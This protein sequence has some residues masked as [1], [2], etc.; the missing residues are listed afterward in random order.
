MLKEVYQKMAKIYKYKCIILMNL[1][2]FRDNISMMFN[3]FKHLTSLEISL[4]H[5]Y[6]QPENLCR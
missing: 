4:I 1:I 2:I 6:N 5:I 3:A